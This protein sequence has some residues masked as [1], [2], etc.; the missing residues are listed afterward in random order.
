MCR[1]FKP[2]TTLNGSVTTRTAINCYITLPPYVAEP[3]LL[4]GQSCG[5]RF[6]QLRHA[7]ATG[8]RECIRH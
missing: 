5:K 8:T 6:H 7:K 2:R 3:E 1:S 4:P